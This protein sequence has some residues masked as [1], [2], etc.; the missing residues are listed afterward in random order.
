MVFCKIVKVLCTDKDRLI[1]SDKMTGKVATEIYVPKV[2]RETELEILAV[3]W[4]RRRK[5]DKT[6]RGNKRGMERKG[7][8]SFWSDALVRFINLRFARED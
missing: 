4:G 3:R 7:G 1:K 6:S 8:G 5:E 2:V